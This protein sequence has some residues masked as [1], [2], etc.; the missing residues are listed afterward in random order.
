MIPLYL[1]PAD[2]LP[3]YHGE[4]RERVLEN[5]ASN[6]RMALDSERRRR[7]LD[8][9]AEGTSRQRA[10]AEFSEPSS[11]APARLHLRLVEGDR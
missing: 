9:P 8:R 7:G 4:A 2:V 11:S 5:I 3:G 1:H 6:V 10:G